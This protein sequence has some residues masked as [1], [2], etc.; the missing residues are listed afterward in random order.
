[1]V[2]HIDDETLLLR[3]ERDPAAFTEFY[4]RHVSKVE[5]VGIRRLPCPEQ[6]A[7]LVATVFLRVIESA[8][9]FDPARGRAV[10]WLYA[11]AA[12]V[13][14]D[15]RRRAAR[16]ART[17]ERLEGRRFLDAEDL[18][19]LEEQIDAAAAARRVVDAIDHLPPGERE[20][21]ELVVV[22]GLSVR[23]AAHALGVRPVAAKMRLHRARRRLRPHLDAQDANPA[24][25]VSAAPS[26]AF[27][28]QVTT[29]TQPRR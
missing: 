2:E 9:S 25:R 10:P 12:N 16:R 22:E 3:L 11:I 28:V 14:A 4:R 13:A 24:P 27:S 6:V 29:S 26:P 1:M 21:L 15:E 8:S 7:D 20:L 5:G 23:D 17:R 19:R 18:T